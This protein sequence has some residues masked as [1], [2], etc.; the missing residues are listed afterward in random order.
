M[1]RKRASG[2]ISATVPS[3]SISSSLAIGKSCRFGRAVLLVQA[4]PSANRGCVGGG[5]GLRHCHY[6][7]QSSRRYAGADELALAWALLR[8][9]CFEGRPGE[10][11]SAI[12][13]RQCSRGDTLL[14]T[15]STRRTGERRSATAHY[16][17]PTPGLR[18]PRRTTCIDGGSKWQTRGTTN[19]STS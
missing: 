6:D 18:Y 2:S 7:A 13:S 14:A 15:L 4:S 3:I 5:P 8:P 12:F 10:I 17:R 11:L 16:I 19:R 9:P 1:T